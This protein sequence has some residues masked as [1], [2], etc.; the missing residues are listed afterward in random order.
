MNSNK[1]LLGTSGSLKAKDEAEPSQAWKGNIG[2]TI[3]GSEGGTHPYPGG[4]EPHLP[5]WPGCALNREEEEAWLLVIRL[6]SWCWGVM[7]SSG[8]SQTRALVL[9]PLY[10]QVRVR[11]SAS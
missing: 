6:S 1:K 2:L 3:A 8:W 7:A 4:G 10:N 11:L 5:T 9:A